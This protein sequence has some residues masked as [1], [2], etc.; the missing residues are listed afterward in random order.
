[1]KRSKINNIYDNILHM[2]HQEIELYL[3]DLGEVIDD[4]KW[5][6][7]SSLPVDYDVEYDDTNI[8][9]ASVG[10]SQP[11]RKSKQDGVGNSGTN[12]RVRYS[13]NPNRTGT[14]SREF[15][16]LMVKANKVYRKEDILKMSKKPVNKG[17]GPHGA[18]TYSIWKYKG[19]P[20][21]HHQWYRQIYIEQ[22]DKKIS[23]TKVRSD[24]YKPPVNE[25]EVSVK[26]KDMPNCGYLPSNPNGCK[27]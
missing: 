8:D 26:P 19:G 9:L 11:H 4:T 24:G 18:S 6:L 15:C 16:K 7:L 12:Y 23:T 27:K 22:T 17:F 3:D 13:Y 21:C 14:N 2:S 25:Q 20:Q 1:M 10:T 5:K